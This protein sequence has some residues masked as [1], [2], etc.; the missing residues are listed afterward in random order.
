MFLK[1]FILSYSRE[2]ISNPI[3]LHKMGKIHLFSLSVWS[4]ES[5]EK[6]ESVECCLFHV[7]QVLSADFL[8]ERLILASFSVQITYLQ[9]GIKNRAFYLW[10]WELFFAGL[11]PFPWVPMTWF[12]PSPITVCTPPPNNFMIITLIQKV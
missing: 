4:Q 8:Q 11:F 6:T 5:E 3:T 7:P 12:Y 9:T 1:L 10:L 2:Y